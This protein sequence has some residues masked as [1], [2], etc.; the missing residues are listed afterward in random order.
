MGGLHLS[1]QNFIFSI[2]RR[3]TDSLTLSL[4][5]SCNEIVNRIEYLG[6][7]AY[8]LSF[9]DAILQAFSRSLM[10][11]LKPRPR[12]IGNLI[13]AVLASPCVSEGGE[14]SCCSMPFCPVVANVVYP[15]KSCKATSAG[16]GNFDTPWPAICSSRRRACL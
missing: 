9:F 13:A 4:L 1:L 11:I 3:S 14:T 12:M 10:Q 5:R 8:V 7:P 15:A 2:Q 6:P 16:R